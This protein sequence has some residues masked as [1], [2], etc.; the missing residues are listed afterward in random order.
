MMHYF[1]KIS[2]ILFAVTMVLAGCGEIVTYPD[3]PIIN[4][5]SFAIY[6]TTD[7]LGDLLIGKME[8]TF[9]DGDGD[10]G[11]QQPTDTIE[12]PD[13]LKF[14]FFTNLYSMNNGI[15]EKVPDE[16]GLQNFRIPY[17]SREGQNKTIKGSIFIDF[18]Y[19][20]TENDMVFDTIFYTF[21]LVD[22]N[23][24]KSNTDTSEVL[25]FTGLDF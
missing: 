15:F 17:I 18:E 20:I 16:K 23:Y 13:S 21:Y 4:Y 14:N 11:L 9:T 24:H 19:R 10:I 2:A 7:E 25:V 12:V 22:R 6:K 8:V 3:T 5:K 1:K